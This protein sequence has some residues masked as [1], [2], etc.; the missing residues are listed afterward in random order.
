MGTDFDFFGDLAY[1]VKEKEMADSGKLDR[2]QVRNRAFLREVMYGAGFF[3]IQ[4]EWW[5]FN[6]CRR[7][8]AAKWYP[9]I[10]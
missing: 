2:S 10:P 7:D 5:H 9:I 4:T 1:P 8:S 6:S 3:G